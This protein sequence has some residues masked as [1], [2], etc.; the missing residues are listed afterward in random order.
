MTNAVPGSSPA[1][2]RIP[3]YAA[4][5][6]HG[7]FRRP[8]R[9]H[10]PRHAWAIRNISLL[11]D[12]FA[13]LRAEA[14]ARLVPNVCPDGRRC[15]VSQDSALRAGAEAR[16][17]D[18]RLCEGR[19]W[20]SS[21]ST[22]GPAGGPAEALCEVRSRRQR[23]R[24]ARLAVSVGVRVPASRSTTISLTTRTDAPAC[25]RELAERATLAWPWPH[26]RLAG[27]SAALADL[28][29]TALAPSLIAP[30]TFPTSRRAGFFRFL[31]T[32]SMRSGWSL[33]PSRRMHV[34][35]VKSQQP[36]GVTASTSHNRQMRG[37][38]SSRARSCIRSRAHP[39]L[40]LRAR[41]QKPGARRAPI[42]PLLGPE[43]RSL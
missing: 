28:T 4:D 29:A 6:A 27:S 12:R 33:R 22:S 8:V 31:R 14:A 2:W 19:F 24:L 16:P 20:A 30:L 26:R 38:V 40:R 5:H 36:R 35:D 17:E 41:P 10:A 3:A 7:A 34:N 1:C 32:S 37:L 18:W 9:R 39:Q 15:G 21:T 43:F 11:I 23:R 13:E 42:R 25:W